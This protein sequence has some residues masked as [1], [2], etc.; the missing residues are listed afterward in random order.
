MLLLIGKILGFIPGLTD[1]ANNF[2]TQHYNAQ[3]QQ[4]IARWGVTRDVAVAAIQ[5]SSQVQTRWWFVAVT[6]PAFALPVAFYM[7]KVLVWDMCLGL[8]STPAIMDPTVKYA[9]V[10]VITGTFGAG[11]LSRLGK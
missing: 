4:Y 2:I 10:T 7:A 6:V 9:V 5:G 3:V 11:I 1:L 8:G